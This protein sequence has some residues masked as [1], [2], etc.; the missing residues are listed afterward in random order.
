LGP[1][2]AG[3]Q[4]LT[5]PRETKNRN[6]KCAGFRDP[7]AF[8]WDVT[9]VRQVEIQRRF[10]G[11]YCLHPYDHCMLC[12]HHARLKRLLLASYWLHAWLTLR[13]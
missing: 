6:K 2:V 9:S 12:K 11:T 13:S 3:V 8:F 10:G 5:P 4:I 1:L 7:T